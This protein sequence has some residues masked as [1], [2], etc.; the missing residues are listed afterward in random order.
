MATSN[1][2]LFSKEF[3]DK[4]KLENDRAVFLMNCATG[5]PTDNEKLA[6]DYINELNDEINRLYERINKAN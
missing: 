1:I 5:N 4:F 6:A 2:E 3:R